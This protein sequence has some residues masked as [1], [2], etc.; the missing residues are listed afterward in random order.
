MKPSHAQP[1]ITH[2]QESHVIE[3]G[4]AAHEEKAVQ[5]QSHL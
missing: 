1:E 5:M 3:I 2:A 4:V